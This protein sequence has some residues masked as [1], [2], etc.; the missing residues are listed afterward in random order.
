MVAYTTKFPINDSL[1]KIQFVKTVIK[2]NQGS[3]YDKISDLVWDE[4]K[5][6]CSW[7]KKI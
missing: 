5:F 7:D 6:D 1:T 3:R 4:S 2:W